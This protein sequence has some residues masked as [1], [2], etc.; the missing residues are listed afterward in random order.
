M[1]SL[2]PGEYNINISESYF[3]FLK[4]ISEDYIKYITN[5]KMATSD[6]L[7]KIILNQEKYSPQLLGTKEQPKD[8]NVSHIISL[9][10]IIPKIIK[11]QIIN[12]ECFID[13]IDSKFNKYE[14]LLKNKTNEFFDCQ[15]LF[16]DFK[17][18][19]NRKYKEIE[20]IKNNYMSSITLAEE[21]INKYYKKQ[22]NKKKNEFDSKMM[23][24]KTNTNELDYISIEEQLNSIIQKTKKIEEEYKSNIDSTK[25]TEN[26]YMKIMVHSKDEMRKILCEVSNGLK[27]LISENIILLRNT[28]KIPLKELDIYLDDI[29]KVEEFLVFNKDIISSYKDT[30]KLKPITPEKYTLKIFQGDKRNF[31]KSKSGPLTKINSFI[32]ENFQEMDYLQEEVVFKTIKKMKE[33]FELIEKINFDLESEEEK[34]RCK[35][36]TWK[37]LSFA[38]D[39]IFNNQTQKISDKEIEEIHKM[40]LKKQNRVI[41]IQQL[42]QFRTRGIFDIPKREYDILSGLLNIIAK[43]IESDKDYD[44]AINII[45]LSQTYYVIKDNKKEYLQNAIMNNE[46][47]KNIKFWETYVNYAINKELNISKE[48]D[49]KNGIKYLNDKEK[50]EKMSNIVFS[51]LI[52][53]SD[54]MIEFGLD[55]NVVEEIILPL[56]KKYKISPEF[57]E[58]VL[59]TINAK[60]QELLLKGNK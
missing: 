9:T 1:N 56:I 34:L 44:S 24:P 15:N 55:V 14:K 4:Q 12:I 39:N 58:I 32:E 31:R 53:I 40:L 13:T 45:I 50:E 27:E 60:K 33:N 48:A 17:N 11:Q 19:L 2:Y 52:P 29:I 37:I 22:N 23:L 54:N 51:Q 46:L 10:S 42:S 28:Y 36:L 5:Y 6:Y 26:N 30:N 18:E 35:Y 3:T 49:K 59:S 57:S 47:F 8:I 20:Q 7:K 16:K 43:T 38:D 41:F 25:S 21:T